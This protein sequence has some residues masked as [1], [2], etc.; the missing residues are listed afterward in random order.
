V[1]V[2]SVL[3]RHGIKLDVDGMVDAALITSMVACNKL[4]TEGCMHLYL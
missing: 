4:I 2:H 1:A 3:I